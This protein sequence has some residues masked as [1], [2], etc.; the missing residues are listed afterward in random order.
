MA[1]LAVGDGAL[2]FWS[3]LQVYPETIHQR[4]W[5]HKSDHVLANR[6]N[7]LQSKAKADLQAIWMVPT[8]REAKRAFDRFVKRYEAKY[9]KATTKLV[10]DRAQLLAF[11][12]FPSAHWIHLRTTNP[13]KSSAGTVDPNL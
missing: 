2:G 6:P 10:K 12:A 8:Q 9:P 5:L 7:S 1:S 3:A 4:C 11:Y 13:I